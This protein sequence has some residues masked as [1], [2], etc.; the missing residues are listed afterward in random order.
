MPLAIVFPEV[1][2]RSSS[3]SAICLLLIL[4]G[5]VRAAAAELQDLTEAFAGAFDSMDSRSYTHAGRPGDP[6][7]I[8]IIASEEELLRTMARAGWEPADPITVRSSL[9]IAL[10]SVAH[11]PYP[12][13]PVSNLY[14]RGRKQDLAFEQPA[15]S[16]PSKRHHVRFWRMESADPP[17]RT[18]WMGAATYD[19]SIGVS[20]LNGH[21]TH[22]IGQDVDGERDKLVG[23]IQRTG[24]TSVRWLDGFQ[25]E[26]RGR[27]GG[28]DFF[29]TDG[30]L[31]IITLDDASH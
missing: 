2:R 28:G 10:D 1:L 13:A 7:N 8:A 27:N 18:I 12:D 23:D 5:V 26:L 24:A 30:R 31:A 16:S 11:K 14:V 6:L 21:I 22:H 4:A 20:H 3:V 9:R 19:V 29:Y 15:G 17:N 25:K